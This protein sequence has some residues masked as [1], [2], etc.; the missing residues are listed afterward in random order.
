MALRKALSSCHSREESKGD[1]KDASRLKM[2]GKAHHILKERPPNG[3]PR[4][5]SKSK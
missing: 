4:S 5:S 1:G 3:G 2:S